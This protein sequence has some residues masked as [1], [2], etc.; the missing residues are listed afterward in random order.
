MLVLTRKMGEEIVINGNI[1]ITVTQI[2]PNRVKLGIAAPDQVSI[3][4]A[5]LEPEK[6]ED[7]HDPSSVEDQV[8]S[9]DDQE[10]DEEETVCDMLNWLDVCC[11]HWVNR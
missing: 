5:E 9:H 2:N 4:R 10:T 1:L 11:D 8:S 6:R 7:L 3:R